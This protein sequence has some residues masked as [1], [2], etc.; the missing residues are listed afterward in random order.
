MPL[1]AGSN[2]MAE[3]LL[4]ENKS[5]DQPAPTKTL[6]YSFLSPPLFTHAA[7]SRRNDDAERGEEMA[8]PRGPSP[9]GA[10]A[11]SQSR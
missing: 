8:S 1:A 10:S 4:G 9:A 7:A 11:M 6:A 3:L 2:M 5:Q